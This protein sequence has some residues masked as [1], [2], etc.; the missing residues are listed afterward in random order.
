MWANEVITETLNM[1]SINLSFIGGAA[2]LLCNCREFTG[3]G[4]VWEIDIQVFFL[5]A[6]HKE[7]LCSFEEESHLSLSEGR[8]VAGSATDEHSETVCLFRS[9]SHENK[10]SLILFL[11]ETTDC[12]FNSPP[13]ASLRPRTSL[14]SVR[15][16]L[17]PL[18]ACCFCTFTS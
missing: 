16:L 4:A 10:K 1:S 9:F 11:P 13:W 2:F 15:L 5:T 6:K 12:S 17:L 7:A 14:L 18:S 8:K 3:V